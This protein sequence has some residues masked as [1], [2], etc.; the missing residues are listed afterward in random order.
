MPP[1]H[2]ASRPAW[3]L[4]PRSP[5]MSNL[6]SRKS[7]ALAF[8]LGLL[9]AAAARAENVQVKPGL[10]AQSNITTVN[11]KQM[12]MPNLGAGA[13]EY[14]RIQQAAKQIGLPEGGI[15]SLSCERKGSYDAREL[16]AKE[17]MASECKFDVLDQRRDGARFS[18][19]CQMPQGGV[20]QG[21]GEVTILNGGTE[22]RMTMSSRAD[23]QG[24]PLNVEMK[25]VS[26]WIGA[27]C[28]HP[29]AGID[30]SWVDRD[31]EGSG[32]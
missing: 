9:A 24:K 32:E 3:P 18:L 26:K 8:S 5:D 31:T 6:P 23:I 29:P 21:S 11:G 27:D 15:P 22:A 16:L 19:R 4:V 2:R 28:A 20:S 1:Y 7:L 17:K 25:S 12:Q 30:P 14:Q 13:Q 10:W